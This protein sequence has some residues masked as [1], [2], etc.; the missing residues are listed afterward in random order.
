[1]WGRVRNLFR[2][3]FTT[4]SADPATEAIEAAT[5][6]SDTLPPDLVAAIEAASVVWRYFEG[7]AD[8][9]E[10]SYSSAVVRIVGLGGMWRFDGIAE[11][12][13][14]VQKHYP[15]LTPQACRRA[16]KMIAA[17]IGKRNLLAHRHQS[18]RGRWSATDWG[19]GSW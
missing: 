16:A 5:P 19:Q 4:A 12:A 6:R 17:E 10:A 11:A 3:G 8:K 13:E 9:D 14:R 1:M 15:D 7:N 18:R 2:G